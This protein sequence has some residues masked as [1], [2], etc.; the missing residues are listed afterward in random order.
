LK[1]GI[2]WFIKNEETKGFEVMIK[3]KQRMSEAMD[4]KE[5]DRVPVMCQMSI[6]H[7]LLQTGFSPSEFWF[8][9]ELFAEGLL[10]MREIYSFDGI[11]ISLHGHSPDWEKDVEE[12]KREEDLEVVIWKNGD[13][14]EFP[15]DDLPR[16]YP[17][18][19]DS[20][21]SISDLDPETIPGELDYIPVSQG[22]EFHLDHEHRYD[23]FRLVAQKAGKEYSIH[24]EVT[25]PFDYF[26]NLVGFKQ[27]LVSLMENPEKCLEILQRYTEGVKKIALE[28][29]ELGLDAI[30]ISSPFAGS[31]FISPAFYRRF[32]LP[33][34]SQIAQAVR[35]QGTHVY[36]HTC[37]A[38][39]DRLETMVESGIS[40]LEC[41]DPPPL[42]NVRLEEAK[43]RIGNKVFIKG[44][45]DPVNVLLMGSRDTIELDAKERIEI[46]KPGGGFI[47]STACSIAPRTKREHI[48]VL[49]QVA[50]KVGYY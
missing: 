50:E 2:K 14:T 36:L 29:T 8:T 31:G 35:S 39:D 41:L 37:G 28:Q 30:K 32:V 33:F 20:P 4:R 27:A 26:L 11:L 43:K 22:L 45:I 5:P 40:G 17:A 1:R 44:N 12:L 9:A 23:I 38:I 48:E 7:I 42:G 49:S 24:G 34:E 18:K 13:R 46:G 6:G 47:L 16:H 15:T 3:P 10:R 21:P 19:V 25:S